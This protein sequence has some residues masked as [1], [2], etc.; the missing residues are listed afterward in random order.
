V[1]DRQRP[2]YLAL[3]IILVLAFVVRLR[4][5]WFGL[6]FVHARPDE[7]LIVGKALGFFTTDLNPRFFD[8][9]TLYIY[10]VGVLFAGYYAFGRLTG[11]FT[12]PAQ[13]AGGTH[14]RW[15]FLYVLSRG[16][17]AVFG[18][19]TV[20]WVYRIGA[21]VFDRAI[22]LLAAF[23]LALAF[24]HV[25]DSHYGTTD[26]TQSFFT[27]GAVL[28][29]LRLHVDRRRSHAIFAAVYAGLAMGTKYNGVLLAVPM[30][31]V[32]LVHAWPNRRSWSVAVRGTYLPLMAVVMAVTFLATTPYLI[33]DYPRAIADFEALRASM[34]V[35]MT[36]RELLGPGWIYHFR[37]SLVFGLGVPLL[38][39]SLAGI[40]LAAVRQ[41]IVTLLLVSYP[42]AYYLLAGASANVFVRYMIPVVPFLC[43]FGAV[44]VDWVA[45]YV[46]AA[47][48]VAKP[49]VTWAIAFIVIAP[50]AWSV[51]AYDVVLARQDSRVM[52]AD[53]VLQNVP[54]GASVYV[55]G[56]AYGHPPLED[57]VDPKWHL[58]TWDY[59]ASNFIEGRKRFFGDPD[60]I[61]VQRS[62]LPYSHIPDLVK[63]MLPEHYSLVTAIQAAD[64]SQP[65]NVYDIQDAFYLPYGG[66]R[67]IRRPG[68]NLEIY[69]RV[70]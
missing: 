50:S 22:G 19:A 10:L 31:L 6:P 57:R 7:L 46:A 55:T 59:R 26:I 41:P 45:G 54:R 18:T 70:R 24:L 8:Y 63:E 35:G 64:L 47:V 61:I 56:N 65:G 1:S 5:I 36:P 11:W 33:L 40:V 42:L 38:V 67:G 48:R 69:R 37:F 25:R 53:W 51:V 43:I 15:Q 60:W 14:G 49:I 39:A 32:E 4:G 29:L 13:F 44:F 16:A 27:M 68:P 52:A 17:T 62:A 23:F 9:P 58:V 34:N 21:L 12:D 3:G 30:T 28:S 66:F 20:A 2:P